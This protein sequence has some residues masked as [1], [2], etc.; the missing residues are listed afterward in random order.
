MC[1]KKNDFILIII[2][3]I[4]AL[5]GLLFVT[6]YMGRSGEFAVVK[7]NGKEVLRV[8]LSKEDEYKI[9]TDNG[10]NIIKVVDGTVMV[11]D[12]DCKNKIC[13]NHRPIRST[14]ESIICLPHKLIVE[15]EKEDSNSEVDSESK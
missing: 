7:E 13:V 5:T 1:M 4:I 12:S 15:I 14:S 3:T 2:I 11:I 9:V 8:D 10:F 6:N